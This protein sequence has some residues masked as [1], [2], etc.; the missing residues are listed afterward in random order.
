MDSVNIIRNLLVIFMNELRFHCI[1]FHIRP[2][3]FFLGVS[4]GSTL[5][6]SFLPTSKH[7]AVSEAENFSGNA[8]YPDGSP[9]K[10]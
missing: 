7:V 4:R 8:I 3:F 6:V 1:S 5:A 9:N 10:L 2:G